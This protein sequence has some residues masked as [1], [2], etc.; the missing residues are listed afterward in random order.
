MQNKQIQF[1]TFKEEKRNLMV[2]G[3]SIHE[4]GSLDYVRTKNLIFLL[5]RSEFF[6]QSEN[7]RNQVKRSNDSPVTDFHT[8]TIVN[9]SSQLKTQNCCPHTWE[10]CSLLTGYSNLFSYSNENIFQYFLQHLFP[11]LLTDFRPKLGYLAAIV[12]KQSLILEF[13]FCLKNKNYF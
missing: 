2:F 13:Y 8:G 5:D 3:V 12:I 9:L 6:S 7:S 10:M 1:S 4:T 11:F